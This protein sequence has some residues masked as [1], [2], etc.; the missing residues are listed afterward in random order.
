MKKLTTVLFLFLSILTSSWALEKSP[1]GNQ[2]L[3][4]ID[5]IRFPSAF[6]MRIALTTI[7]P[8]EADKIMVLDST[9]KKGLGSCIEVQA[10]SRSKG[11]RFLTQEGSLWMYNPKSGSTR[12]LRLANKD[13]FQ[14]S[15][16]SNTDVSK[17]SFTEEYKGIFET[18][19][20]VTHSEFGQVKAWRLRAEATSPE[21]AY[22]KIVMWVRKGDLLPLRFEYYAKSGLLFRTMLLS[23]Y[24]MMAGRLRA[25]CMEMTSVDKSNTKSTLIIES[26]R[27]RSDISD[28][29]FNLSTLTR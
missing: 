4:E 24:K 1:D 3:S 17:T 2:L 5:K 13:S 6:T 25:T 9:Y 18:E 27:E 29:L 23:Q 8:G 15:T 14:G 12:P 7:T 22:S 28:S 16:F 20:T 10:P 11:T 19:E 26:M 21:A